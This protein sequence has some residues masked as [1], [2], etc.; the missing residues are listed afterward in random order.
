MIEGLHPVGRLSTSIEVAELI[1]WL[2]SEKSS[3]ASGGYYAIDGGYL[4]Q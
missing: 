3:F 2:G 1:F 4:A